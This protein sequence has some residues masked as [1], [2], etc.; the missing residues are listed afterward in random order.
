MTVSS[1]SFERYRVAVS[2]MRQNGAYNAAVTDEMPNLGLGDSG[3]QAYRYPDDQ[4]A[5]SEAG[6]LDDA[7]TELRPAVK[8]Q[9]EYNPNIP[10]GSQH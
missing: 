10:S 9:P 8:Q 2:I 5:N 4:P 3:E 7:A 1:V 6:S